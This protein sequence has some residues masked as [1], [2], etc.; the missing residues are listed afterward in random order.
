[1]MQKET[2]VK[3]FVIAIILASALAL[4]LAGCGG[5]QSPEGSEQEGDAVAQAYQDA[6]AALESCTKNYK[7]QLNRSVSKPVLDAGYQM[8][9][10]ELEQLYNDGHAA[11]EA[12]DGGSENKKECLDQL[13]VVWEDSTDAINEL[14][15]ELLAELNTRGVISQDKPA[16]SQ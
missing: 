7:D 11:I 8:A 5:Q 3:R 4:A 1:M 6:A 16:A 10:M 9:L 14:Y 2:T 13:A 12:A 15:D